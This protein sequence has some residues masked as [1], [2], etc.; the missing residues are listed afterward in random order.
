MKSP[1]NYNPAANPAENTTRA[2]L[3]LDAM[4][5]TGASTPAQHAKAMAEKHKD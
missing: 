3:A 4:V 5:G 1:T 2:A